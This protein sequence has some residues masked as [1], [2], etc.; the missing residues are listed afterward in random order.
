MRQ[1]TDPRTSSVILSSHT[2]N[3]SRHRSLT[4]RIGSCVFL[5]SL[6]GVAFVLLLIA[7]LQAP[8]VNHGIM[9]QL[10]LVR[11]TDGKGLPMDYHHISGIFPF[12]FTMH[13]V[14]AIDPTGRKINVGQA[15]IKVTATAILNGQV[16]IDSVTL[17]DST[18]SGGGGF[19][20]DNSEYTANEQKTAEHRSK[21]MAHGKVWPFM[22]YGVKVNRLVLA[23]L[24]NPALTGLTDSGSETVS[25]EGSVELKPNGGSFHI[26]VHVLSL[27]HSID[28]NI[29]LDGDHSSRRVTAVIGARNSSVTCWG[30]PECT[31]PISVRSIFATETEVFSLAFRS[32]IDTTI[33]GTWGGL[34]Q[35]AFPSK[36]WEGTED[37]ISGVISI[38]SIHQRPLISQAAVVLRVDKNSVLT[39]DDAR[40]TSSLFRHRDSS[41]HLSL[42]VPI[43]AANFTDALLAFSGSIPRQRI[44]MPLP[45]GTMDFTFNVTR[46][47]SGYCAIGKYDASGSYVMWTAGSRFH[48]QLGTGRLSLDNIAIDAFMG[49]MNGTAT[50][51]YSRAEGMTASARLTDAEHQLESTLT[52]QPYDVA[53]TGKL[54]HLLI[55]MNERSLQTGNL[56]ADNVTV[57][58][59]VLGLPSNPYGS[60]A[61]SIG[62]IN[63]GEGTFVMDHMAMSASR[64]QDAVTGSP[65]ELT[66]SSDRDLRTSFTL[67]LV[68]NGESQF[69]GDLSPFEA[70][71]YGNH[72]VW[73][74]KPS[75]LFF[76]YKTQE[77]SLHAIFHANEAV[78]ERNSMDVSITPDRYQLIVNDESYLLDPLILRGKNMHS[79]GLMDG[80][81]Q[82][83]RVVDPHSPE[84]GQ[85]NLGAMN[86]CWREGALFQQDDQ[87]GALISV[88][89][90]INGCLKGGP[91]EGW[92]IG[93]PDATAYIEN[94]R[95]GTVHLAANVT[96]SRRD[97][98]PSRIVVPANVSIVMFNDDSAGWLATGKLFTSIELELNV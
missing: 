33:D 13:G 51:S 70:H 60:L 21:K 31:L 37:L 80:Y 17:S 28:V 7:I 61:V 95:M 67:Y 82:V 44:T 46:G 25:L 22:P 81:I 1:P 47:T 34:M 8:S 23:N 30:T 26:N 75:E 71:I 39:L 83:D 49:H 14:T 93:D 32:N 54:H 19:I 27:A 50:M 24:S 77:F 88:A 90:T 42:Q 89:H 53:G 68:G 86:L 96:A 4:R 9:Q 74:T 45:L 69:R 79:S 87:T 65:W 57:A 94:P 92:G 35:M 56:N 18:T 73:T 64:D 36:H 6:V 15:S 72:R 16:E 10:N 97:D 12:D 41:I 52:V 62:S 98:R 2:Y 63:Y 40:I 84:L 85:F 66:A 91:G 3:A 38:A 5:S 58:A 43:H 78:P 59:S 76:D 20:E 11:T 55:N 29:K 48:Y